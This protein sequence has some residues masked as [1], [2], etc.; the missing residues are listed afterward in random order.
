MGVFVR[1]C[2]SKSIQP[3]MNDG[4]IARKIIVFDVLVS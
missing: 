3:L 4:F 1:K 2:I